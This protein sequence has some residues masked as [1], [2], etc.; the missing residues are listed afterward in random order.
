MLPV[1]IYIFPSE[2]NVSILQLSENLEKLSDS[3]KVIQIDNEDPHLDPTDFTSH[4]YDPIH[5][6][7]SQH[8]KKLRRGERGMF[9]LRDCAPPFLSYLQEEE[10]SYISTIN[11]E[12]L[13][14]IIQPSPS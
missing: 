6:A 14:N 5:H 11:M 12:G 4:S 1:F 13:Y 9:Q 7:T 8:P 2:L 3:P 10:I